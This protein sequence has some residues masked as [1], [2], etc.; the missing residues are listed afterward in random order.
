M[1]AAATDIKKVEKI[2]A[3]EEK[4]DTQHVK[5]IEKELANVEKTE[6]KT[7]KAADKAVKVRSL[8]LPSYS[9][10]LLI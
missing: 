3:R 9:K 1:S 4:Q 10:P 2:I 8:S 6:A 7:A 5:Q